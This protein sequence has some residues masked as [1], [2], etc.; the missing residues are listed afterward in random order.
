METSLYYFKGIQ[1]TTT[2]EVSF[3]YLNILQA[4]IN[5]MNNTSRHIT[6]AVPDIRYGCNFCQICFNADK[7]LLAHLRDSHKLLPKMQCMQCDQNVT[8]RKLA[9]DRWQHQ[10]QQQKIRRS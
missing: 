8:V 9:L 5:N 10:C 1:D 3:S 7:I 4:S 6:E 2:T